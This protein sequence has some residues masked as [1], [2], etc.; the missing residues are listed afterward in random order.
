[1]NTINKKVLSLQY[2]PQTI[3]HRE[4]E[5]KTILKILKPIKE[6]IVTNNI[7]IYGPTGT[8]K[9]TVLRNLERMVDV[10]YIYLNA[11]YYNTSYRA[12]SKILNE[13]DKLGYTISHLI[14][15][16]KSIEKPMIIAIDE[17][18]FVK[19]LDDLLYILSRINEEKQHPI[20]LI[21]ATNSINLKSRLD[22]RTLSSLSDIQIVF[23]PYNASQIRDI[24]IQRVELS[25]GD[26]YEEG[27]INKIAAIAAQENGDA[28]YALKLLS[29]A[30]E[31]AENDEILKIEHVDKALEILEY[32]LV[33]EV[34]KTLPLNLQIVLYSL[35]KSSLQKPKLSDDSNII[36]I[37]DAYSNYSKY[38][39][40]IFKK[41]P[42][43]LKWFKNYLIELE[44]LGLVM[45]LAT[46][47]GN[48]EISL[49]VR[50]GVNPKDILKFFEK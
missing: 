9:T 15:K 30:I 44:N 17:I 48:R 34:I 2:I 25:I 12:L 8:G 31:L 29:K 43:S 33:A 11:R 38:S 5:I 36:S 23:K 45:H 42:K 20:S 21:M 22:S 16:L 46:K 1:M 14:S 39:I 37:N 47:K 49:Y 27:A 24:L 13:E 40:D 18:D 50:L 28:R 4:E 19:D 35:A 26:R 10:D 32:D 6:S 7:I 41:K 3:L